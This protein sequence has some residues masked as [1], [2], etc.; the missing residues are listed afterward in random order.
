MGRKR[1]KK[2]QKWKC[3]MKIKNHWIPAFAGMTKGRKENYE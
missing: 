2:M 1:R 3:K